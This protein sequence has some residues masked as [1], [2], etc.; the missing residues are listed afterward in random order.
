MNLRN[1]S[2]YDGRINE[3]N[4]YYNSTFKDKNL[5]QNSSDYIYPIKKPQYI[6]ERYGFNDGRDCK[7]SPVMNIGKDK[8]FGCKFDK[9]KDK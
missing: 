4:V 3:D 2:S 8:S 7:I 6:F 1:D 9:I 5:N